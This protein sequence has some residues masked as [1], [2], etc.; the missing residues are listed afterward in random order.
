MIDTNKITVEKLEIYRL[1]KG[2]GDHFAKF[3]NAE[4]RKIISLGGWDIVDELLS[5]YHIIKRD[6]AA[7]EY[8]LAFNKK[9]EE[10]FFDQE[11]IQQFYQLYDQ[12]EHW[13]NR[14]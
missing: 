1:Y 10:S 11:A 5:D 8:E 3:A 2:D 4:Q 13:R 9:I 6:L 7:A 14:R 12:L